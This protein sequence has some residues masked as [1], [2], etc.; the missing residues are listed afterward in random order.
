WA[1]IMSTIGILGSGPEAEYPCLTDFTEKVDLWIGV[2]RGALTLINQGITV[3]YAIGDF[4]SVNQS[5]KEYIQR[6]ALS[7]YEYP[8]EKDQTYL[9]ISIEKALSLLPKE[10]YLFGV[11]GGRF[12][13]TLMN[14]QLLL[15]IINKEVRA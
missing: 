2:D 5:E 15:S 1:D 13:H 3:D 9:S 8:I 7:F 14:M 12:D 11:T 4:D 6:I 10:I